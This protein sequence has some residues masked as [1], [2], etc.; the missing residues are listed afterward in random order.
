[1][2]YQDEVLSMAA[3]DISEI[4]DTTSIVSIVFD[5]ILRFYSNMYL[6]P[7]LCNDIRAYS[8]YVISAG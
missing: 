3:D 5:R 7:V 1:M 6:I 4:E 2:S 8:H